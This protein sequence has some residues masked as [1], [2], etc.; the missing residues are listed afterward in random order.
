MCCGGRSGKLAHR[1]RPRGSAIDELAAAA[2]RGP[3]G[4]AP[5]TLLA[6]PTPPHPCGR[7]ETGGRPGRLGNSA[8]PMAAARG[9]ACSSFLES[10]SAQVRRDLTRTARNRGPPREGHLRASNCGITVNPDLVRAQVEG[11]PSSGRLAAAAWGR[12]RARRRRPRSS[13][14]TS[15]RYPVMRMKSVATDRRAADP[16]GPSRRLGR[17]EVSVPTAGARPG[18]PPFAAAHRNPDPPAFPIAKTMRVPPEE[19]YACHDH[20]KRGRLLTWWGQA[21]SI[22]RGRRLAMF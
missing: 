1:I 13:P 8:G 10:H 3:R 2:G 7:L 20:P 14:R 22:R 17:R 19:R 18:Q 12:D 6:G 11:R 15:D 9:V 5:R 21:A 16:V 4:P